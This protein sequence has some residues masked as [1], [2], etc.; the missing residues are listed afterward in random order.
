[1][2]RLRDAVS[3][4][5]DPEAGLSLIEIMVA[6]MIFSIITI[7]VAFTISNTLVLTRDS[8]NRETAVNLASQAIDLDRSFNDVQTIKVGTVDTSVGNTTYHVNTSGQWVASGD[9]STVCGTGGGIL[10]FYRVTVRVTWD[11]QSTSTAPV[12]TDTVIAPNTRINDPALGSILVGVTNSSGSGT[13][14]V[15]VTVT[16]KTSGLAV[17]APTTTDGSG[18][19]FF[20]KV[21][22]GSYTVAISRT[23]SIDIS[24]RTAPTKDVTVKA[25][26]SAPATFTYDAA[27]T[28]PLKYAYNAT[29]GPSPV[30]PTNL[31]ATFVNATTGAY[32]PLS[33]T[34]PIQLFP[35]TNG[36]SV[37][38]GSYVG[39]TG[40]SS[41]TCLSPDPA[42]WST[43]N[44]SGAVGTAVVPSATT[45]GGTVS[46]A[47]NVGMGS[48]TVNNMVKNNYLTAVSRTPIAGSGDPGCAIGM[49]YSF[50]QMTNTTQMTIALPYG[51]WAIYQSSTPGSTPL[52]G[53]VATTNMTLQTAG[54]T[55]LLLGTATLDPRGT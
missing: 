28:Y 32:T 14:G 13:S 33:P 49:S 35:S 46:P 54:S 50:P 39:S 6:M 20:F 24:Q 30:L 31:T 2:K 25:G 21:S 38:A 22:P 45:P 53:G 26:A 3:P 12:Y 8:Q 40:T 43:P 47:V 9:N 36:Y 52:L 55:N 51:T 44:S 15:T 34:N 29:K 16:S 41:P 18:C 27:A 11:G 42:A 4:Q 17:P 1:M 10:Q 19:A 37:L 7:G 48:I 5:H 23:N